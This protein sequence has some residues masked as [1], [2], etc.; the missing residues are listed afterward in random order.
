MECRNA[1]LTKKLPE[2]NDEANSA[3]FCSYANFYSFD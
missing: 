1:L 3:Y 2:N